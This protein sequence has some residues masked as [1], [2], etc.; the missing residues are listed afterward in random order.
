MKKTARG[1]TLIE[2]MIVVAILGIITAIGYPSYLDHVKKTRRSEGMGE[3]LELADRME[4]HYSDVGTYDKVVAGVVSDMAIADIYQAATKNGYYTLSIDSG[5]D[6]VD[7]T[8]RAAP[9]SLGQQD[10][11][12]CGTFIITSQGTKTVTGGSLSAPDCWK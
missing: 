4:R 12:K 11:D 6:N 1:M 9:T 2:L 5:T 3:L 7:F 10:T 8:A